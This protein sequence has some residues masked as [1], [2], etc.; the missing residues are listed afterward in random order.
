M[1]GARIRTRRSARHFQDRGYSQEVS[2]AGHPPIKIP[3]LIHI[4]SGNK[5][6]LCPS[7]PCLTIECQP[8]MQ[9]G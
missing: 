9:R 7:F 8:L 1:I 4:S 5:G 6:V 3:E 2:M